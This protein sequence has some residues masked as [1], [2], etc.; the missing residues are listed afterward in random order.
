M[1]GYTQLF[2]YKSSN[3]L[4]TSDK[5]EIEGM[6]GIEVKKKDIFEVKLVNKLP[7]ISYKSN[8]FAAGD[9]AKGSF[10]MEDGRIARL[11]VNKNGNSFL[12][13]RT[14]NGEVYYNSEDLDMNELYK[15]IIQWRG[16]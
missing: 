3:I 2:S 6:Y 12:W 9:Y 14:N 13:L 8:G 4:L 15:K 16:L 11:F 10:K 7:S 5:L 1:V